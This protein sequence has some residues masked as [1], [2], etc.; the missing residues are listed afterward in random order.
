MALSV[1]QL[2]M[3]IDCDDPLF[4]GMRKLK[5]RG[6][7]LTNIP[8]SLFNLIDLEVLDLSPER[9]S[10]L[11][12]KLAEIPPNIGKLVNLKVLC[13]DTNELL[14]VP[15]QICLLK[16][17]ERLAL[18]NN[19]LTSL[20]AGFADLENLTSLHIANNDFTEFPKE[21]CQLKNLQFL[22]LSDNH[23]V[24][25]P[26][27]IGELKQLVTLLLF[28]NDLTSLP[29][30]LCSLT[31]LTC[32]WVGNNRIQQLP[33][34][35]GNLRKLDWGVRYTSSTLDGNPLIHP[36][37]EI[38]RMGPEAI[39]KYLS[40]VEAGRRSQRSRHTERRSDRQTP[41]AANGY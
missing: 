17:L 35:F 31:E 36:P 39:E 13:L 16:N 2:R 22:D 3:R 28:Y 12:Y 8:N 7:D 6:R 32:L 1:R 11:D 23:L 4:Y 33:R 37:I 14:E 26:E 34:R 29:D 21:V 38:C 27:E 15:V 9:Q 19:N 30:S 24:N 10:C 20:P 41:P 5:I 18:S 25:L 40:S